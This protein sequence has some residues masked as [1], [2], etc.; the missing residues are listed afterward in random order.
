[1]G[2]IG[3]NSY[4]FALY[5]LSMLL[6]GYEIALLNPRESLQQIKKRQED[7]GKDWTYF[8]DSAIPLLKGDN[9]YPFGDISEFEEGLPLA[10]TFHEERIR[11][12]VFTSGSTGSSKIVQQTERSIIANVDS[13]IELHRLN[14]GDTCIASPLPLY[15]VNAL[16]FTLLCALLSGQKAVFYAK[17]DWSVIL[18]SIERDQVHILSLF[19]A[20]VDQ[21][22]RVIKDD[23][24]IHLLKYVVTAASSL[25]IEVSKA[26]FAKFKIPLVQGYGLSEAVNFSCLNDPYDSYENLKRWMTTY[27]WPSIGCPIRGNE[28]VILR[29]DGSAAQEN[30]TGELGIRGWNVMA[31]YQNDPDQAVFGGNYLHTG[32]RGHFKKDPKTEKKFFFI[33]G[34]SKDV[35]KRFGETVSLREVDDELQKALMDFQLEI[36]GVG[37]ENRFSG[38]EIGAVISTQIPLDENKILPA[39]MKIADTH[40]P[41]I[42]CFLDADL[43]TSSGKP[44]RWKFKSHFEKFKDSL[45]AKGIKFQNEN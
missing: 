34:R 45:F 3:G 12:R 6:N 30:E 40:R 22:I 13:L 43:R 32:D 25:S 24:Q 17:T 39:L 35:I 19:P 27:T 31:G 26:W 29:D 38:E 5:F 41:R 20:L 37:F 11:I 36:I 16:E 8:Y 4:Q 9:L 2:L 23:S 33:E 1:A 28:V 44:Q 42:I 21:F 15:H 7:L 14:K 18:R 10:A